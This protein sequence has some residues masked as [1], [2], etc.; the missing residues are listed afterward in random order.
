MGR[1]GAGNW[2]EPKELHKDGTFTQ[3]SDATAIPTSS[4]PQISTPWH[5]EGQE[6]PVARSGRGGAGN[7]VWKS[8]EQARREREGRELDELKKKEAVSQEVERDVEAVLARPGPARLGEDKVG[9][10]W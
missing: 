10:G 6:M 2:Y 8:E 3:P 4:K 1:G 9:R 7:F 5:P